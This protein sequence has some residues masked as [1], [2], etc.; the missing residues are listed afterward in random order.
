MIKTRRSILVRSYKIGAAV[1]DKAIAARFS[2]EAVCQF[3]AT[4]WAI[5]GKQ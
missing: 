2:C 5:K 4:C 1:L 3:A